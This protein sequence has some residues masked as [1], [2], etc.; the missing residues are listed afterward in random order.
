M[1]YFLQQLYFGAKINENDIAFL[2]KYYGDAVSP[3]VNNFNPFI[4]NYFC[5][6]IVSKDKNTAYVCGQ[7]I[8]S[9][10]CDYDNRICLVGLDINKVYHIEELNVVANGK[11]LVEAGVLLPRLSDFGT[12]SWHI[13]SVC[14]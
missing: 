7:Q 9:V 10:P 4:E 12:W 13:K 6:M 3:K 1:I 14:S 8:H 2:T 5:R 11:I